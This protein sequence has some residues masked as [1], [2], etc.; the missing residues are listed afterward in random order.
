MRQDIGG[1]SWRVRLLR[2]LVSATLA[3]A[4]TGLVSDQG[5][6]V[7]PTMVS[8]LAATSTSTAAGALVTWSIG[9][10]T[11]ASGAMEGSSG[12]SV[13]VT[14]PT[15]TTF[16]S[17][18]HAN[19]FDT[20]S[21]NFLTTSCTLAGGSA[22]SCNV[23]GGQTVNAGDQLSLS[24]FGATNPAATGPG[25]VS[26]STTSDTAMATVPVS[27][28][29]AQSVTGLTLG[30]VST[31]ADALTT[32]SFAFTT[33]STGGLDGTAGSAI[34]MTLPAGT[35]FAGSFA[36]GVVTDVTT[37][38]TLS[39]QQCSIPSGTTVSCLIP[40]NT[41][42]AGDVV[43][44]LLRAGTNPATTGTTNIAVSTTSDTVTITVPL[45]ITP[46]QSV[47][48]LTVTP[49]STA[50]GG[51]A[52]WTFGFTS[53]S[54]G[55]M[56]AYGGAV[57]LTLPA[58]TQFGSP[59][60]WSITDTTDGGHFGPCSLVS[61]TTVSCTVYYPVDL[62]AGDAFSVSLNGLTN[63]T[64]TGPTTVSVSTSA[65]TKN[66]TA[67]VIITGIL[68]GKLSG[69]LSGKVTIKKCAPKSKPNKLL[70]GL[71]SSLTSGGTLTWKKSHQ[72]TVI[73]TSTTSPT[74]HGACPS[75]S[76][77][78]DISGSVSGGGSTYTHSGD[79]VSL[80]ACE[81]GSGALSLVP[82]TKA[83]L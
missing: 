46:A 20:T 27:I 2:L 30:L 49:S 18:G 61:G 58:G 45:T 41:V 66:A 37:S 21:D 1:S 47:Q 42:R 69:K 55:A 39:I 5:W 13:T 83:I 40:T 15:G 32:W 67:P 48:G 25:T 26:V 17:F 79:Y 73:A 51:P 82:G 23:A 74:G 52:N 56:A 9:F 31:A 75:G 43:S 50:A 78:L 57:T 59:S 10:S 63:P 44:V 6:A 12:A 8:G 76:T 28:T 81:S 22:L 53:S 7:P 14:L 77:E 64:T 3:A 65:D 34:R 80:H 60:G 35:T 33:S 16:G 29:T 38:Q 68:C 36:F 19:M 4:V 70:S 71:G 24:V 11:S 62:N 72:T 54:S